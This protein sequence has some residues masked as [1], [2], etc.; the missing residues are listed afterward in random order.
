[1]SSF[2]PAPSFEGPKEG[3]VFKMGSEGLGYY[4]DV[5]STEAPAPPALPEEP[6]PFALG[7]RVVSEDGYFATVRYVGPV[8]SAKK[9]DATFV[10]VVSLMAIRHGLDALAFN[11]TFTA[12]RAHIVNHRLST[13]RSGTSQSAVSMMARWSP[14]T[15][16]AMFISRLCTQ[17]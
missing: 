6:R 1:M 13:Y 5:A 8:K 16:P 10:G 11:T 4:Q 3:H 14:K 7:Q 15:A 17:Q 2:I 9:A 12:R